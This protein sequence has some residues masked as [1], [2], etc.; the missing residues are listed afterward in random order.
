MRRPL[1]R[2]GGLDIT[3]V[4]QGVRQDRP[5]RNETEKL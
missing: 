2:V 5:M 3:S 4:P 1:M